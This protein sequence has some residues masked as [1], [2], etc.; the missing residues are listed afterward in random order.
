MIHDRVYAAGIES[1]SNP[2]AWIGKACIGGEDNGLRFGAYTRQC[3]IDRQAI[4]L[5]DFYRH[6]RFHTQRHPTVHRHITGDDVRAVSL[7]QGSVAGNRATKRRGGR[8]V[9]WGLGRCRGGRVR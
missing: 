7:V 9:G 6:A 2:I 3:A 8:G 4:I 5:V 1:Y